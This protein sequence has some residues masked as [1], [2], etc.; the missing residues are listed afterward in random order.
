MSE[1]PNSAQ[2]L[3]PFRRI[4]KNTAWLL[5]GK[6]FG[7]IC[8]LAYLAILTRSLGLKD[9]GHFSLI[10]GTALVLQGITGV[11]SWRTVVRFGAAHVHHREWDR[12][13]RLGM[14]CG[15]LDLA[16]AIAG[17]LI[18]AVM[19]YGFA[20]LLDLNRA[21]L[22]M[23]FWFC[24]GMVWALVSAPTGIVRALNRF[25]SAVYVEAVV[26]LGRV[27]AAGIIWWTG[28]SVAKFLL[29]WVL[30][31]LVEAALYW[32][33]ARRLC[34]QAVRLRH[35]R[36]WR[37]TLEEN[38]GLVRFF[39][40]SHAT[41]TLDAVVRL[42][43]LLAVGGLVGTKAA[44][45][46]RLASQITQ[47][48]GKLSMLLTRAVYAEVARASV[49]TDPAAFRKL[50]L[51]A[52]SGAAIAGGVIVAISLAAGD[53]LLALLGGSE[54]VGGGAILVPLA[55]AAS[56]ELASVPFEPVLHATGQAGQALVARL[57]M[58]VVLLAAI[59]VAIGGSAAG[60][61]WAVA[62]SSLA[63][64][65]TTGLFAWLALR[66]HAANASPAAG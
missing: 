26:P 5:G 45:L 51:Q 34:P 59:G 8:G 9:F 64:Y 40:F 57:V 30:I 54:F 42:G 65:V 49:A 56:L 20:D 60:I 53:A 2:E 37:Q 44:G 43:P 18:A 35:L 16:G 27:I 4:L 62:A 11:Q 13:G 61:A 36:N 24:C 32:I 52:S 28:P 29:A 50:A 47:A 21:Y 23:A 63:G 55:I 12:F 3:T 22:D 31:D 48:L 38:P 17:C 1:T 66:N 15:I 33:T 14:F 58:L 41:V 10:F 39:L 25:D 46:Y 7:A 6:G 19:I